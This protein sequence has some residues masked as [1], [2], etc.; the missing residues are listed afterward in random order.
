MII[1]DRAIT[2][3]AG[4]SAIAL[5][6]V[7]LLS[8]EDLFIGS[9]DNALVHGVSFSLRSGDALGI[10]GES[11]SGK[12][13]TCRAVLGA[14][15]RGIGVLGGSVRFKGTELVGLDRRGWGPL[16]GK[17]ISAVFQDP[18]SY[19]NPSIQVGQQLA[20]ALRATLK[21][22]RAEAYRRSLDLLGK[23]GLRDVEAVYRQY[24]FELSGG[25][26]QR[27]LIAIAV[28]AAPE[29]L[30]AD[31]VTTAL[32][33]T[34]QAEVLDLLTELQREQNLAL[35]LV[36]HDLAVVAQMC[37][38]ILVFRHGVI[39]EAGP[40]QR[41]LNDPQHEY[42]RSLLRSHAQF[43][44]DRLPARR[45]LADYVPKP[46]S[47]RGIASLAGPLLQ[48]RGV[49][50]TLGVGR[51][52]RCV[53]QSIDLTVGQGE[54]L[55]VIGETGSGK[56]TLLRTVL[57]LA[58][59]RD[60]SI[61]FD[62]VEIG[63]LRGRSLRDFR[64][65]GR[66]Q[67]VF[68]DPLQSLDPDMSVGQSIA[69]GLLI[70][71]NVDRESIARRVEAVLA[72]VGLDRAMIDRLPRELSGGQRQRV[73]IARALILDPALLLLDEPVSSLDAASRTQIL[74]LLS[75]LSRERGIAQILISHDLGSVAGLADRVAVLYRGRI[76]ES[77]ATCDVLCEP[78]HAYTRLL[79][80]S[81]PTLT[82]GSADKLKRSALRA[83]MS[84]ADKI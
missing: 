54:T 84:L 58:P 83:A 63:G 9:K 33:V 80:G 23:M 11:G 30:I 36:S 5:P 56:T 22:P 29:L 24:P 64:R 15:P 17:G 70:R 69:E 55:A 32:D 20:E 2:A 27:V 1:E 46:P 26:L 50:V 60:G 61:C 75:S 44:I 47:S 49:D 31:E 59:L 76:V 40:A 12:S 73:V 41:V 77:G 16:R 74:Q 48:V 81:A 78:R 10:V 35:I 65:S 34:V 68:Q 67:Y 53:L 7:S 14:L 71:R 37:S 28:C 13:L 8:V 18:G 21:L 57:G 52:S 6:A 25:M 82:D 42:T 3:Q 62:G 38:Q 66:I 43:G 39:V 51:A 4:A 72:A 79:I 19:L 45:S